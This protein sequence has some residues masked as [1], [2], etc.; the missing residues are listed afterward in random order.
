MREYSPKTDLVTNA[1][2]VVGEEWNGMRR[3]KREEG[4]GNEGQ[5]KKRRNEVRCVLVTVEVIQ[6]KTESASKRKR[7]Q[8]GNRV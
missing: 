7:R 1:W 4:K 3:Q 8:V 5:G 6:R 2:L